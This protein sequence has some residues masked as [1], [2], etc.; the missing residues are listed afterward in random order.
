MDVKEFQYLVTIAE[1]GSVTKAGN[2]LYL[3]QSALSKFVKN[4]EA[5]MGT[6]LFNR[7]G[8]QFVP[9]YAGEICIELA[10]KVL[11]VNQQ[12]IDDVEMIVKKGKGRIRLAFHV[13]LSEFFFSVIYPEFHHK[14]PDVDLQLFE[15]NSEKACE[16]LGQGNLDI[17]IAST[18]W[19]SHSRFA[20]ETLRKQR[21]ALV[22][23]EDSPLLEKAT[24]SA[25]PLTLTLDLSHLQGT[26]LILNHAHQRTRSYA[27]ELLHLAGVTPRIV[28]ETV[29]RENALRAAENGVGVAFAPD[30]PVLLIGRKSLR[31][32]YY[33]DVV[34]SHSYANIIY[35]KGRSFSSME[36]DL[37]QLITRHYRLA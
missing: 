27:M 32:L 17:A 15:L 12:M 9:T 2:Q 5:E 22:V 21:M 28:L 31:Y 8:K 19:N 37:I 23:R 3:T 16:M 26:P 11:A 4:K 36:T 35:T 24:C 33:N 29:S 1:L 14:Y 6:P 30:D 20:C 10:R 13:S 25:S 7:I 18:T 34:A